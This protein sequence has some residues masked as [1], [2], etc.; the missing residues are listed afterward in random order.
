MIFFIVNCADASRVQEI[1]IIFWQNICEVVKNF[2][3]NKNNVRKA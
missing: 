1:H 3:S 2:F